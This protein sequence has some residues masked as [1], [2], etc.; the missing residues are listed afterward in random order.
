MH[1]KLCS[2]SPLPLRLI[3]G[4]SFIYHG[5]PKV[6]SAEGHQT[7]AKLLAGIGVPVPGPMAWVVGAIEVGAGM[8]LII[9]AFV[10]FASVLLA[11]DMLVA[12]FKVHLAAGFSLM[13]IKGTG[14]D[15]PV[16]GMPGYEVNLLYIGALLAL[17][18]LGGGALSIDRRRGRRS[19]R[20][21]DYLRR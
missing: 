8:A 16:F 20:Y 9:G 7:F 11:I 2:W 19:R 18:L 15:G 21:H 14:P 4:I 5:Y 3:L 12:L 10:V 1:E 6:S 13:N 17:I